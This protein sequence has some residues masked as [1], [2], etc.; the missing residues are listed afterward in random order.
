MSTLEHAPLVANS[1]KEAAETMISEGSPLQQPPPHDTEESTA[2]PAEFPRW[3]AQS[4][5]LV[6]EFHFSSY[7]ACIEFVNRVADIAEEMN[8]HPEMTVSWGKVRL[9]VMTHSKKAVTSL[10]QEFVRKVEALCQQMPSESEASL[11]PT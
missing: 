5:G 8:H 1:P 11:A 6:A 2:A 4:E 9:A 7:L 3:S 10:D